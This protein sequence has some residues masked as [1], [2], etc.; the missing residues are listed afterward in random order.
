MKCNTHVAL[1]LTECILAG[2]APHNITPCR[3][4]KIL[5]RPSNELIAAA[6][7]P[8]CEVSGQMFLRIHDPPSFAW[9]LDTHAQV[10]RMPELLMHAVQC[11][12]AINL[13]HQIVYS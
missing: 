6:L 4:A 10:Q 12:L 3:R 7:H 1:N 13:H 2:R 5:P 11:L 8:I 9:S